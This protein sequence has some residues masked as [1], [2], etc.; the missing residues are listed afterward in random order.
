M[1]TRRVLLL[2]GCRQSGKTTLAK[3]LVS[4]DTEYRTLDDIDMLQA[5]RNDPQAFAKHNGHK[6]LIIDEVQHAP[7]LLPAIKKVVDENTRPG[8]YLLTGSANIQS[9]PGVIES[10]AGRVRK[11][12]LRPLAQGE[13]FGQSPTFLEQA[14][15]QSFAH[16]YGKY[17]KDNVLQIAFRGG[18]AEVIHL[19]DLEEGKIWY[20]DYL[21]S[22]LER[23]LKDIA[24]IRR[25]ASMRGLLKALAAWSS[26]FMDISAISSGL[27]LQR[28]TIE[29]Y[30]NALE[31]LYIIERL[32]PWTSTDYAR[33]AKQSKLFMTDCGLMSSLLGWQMDQVRLDVDRAGKMIETFVYNQLMAQIEAN[34]KAYEIYHYRDR[35]QREIDFLIENDRGALLGIEVKAGSV[36]AE[37]NFKHL[38][39]FKNNLAKKRP[40][41]GIVLYTGQVTIP[42]DQ[43]MWGIPISILWS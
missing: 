40:F 31:A 6:T 14:F 33:V 39:W 42:F 37:D 9:L 21:D 8:Q 18:Y 24:N 25:K 36:L 23:D 41:I 28:P 16:T 15:Q 2:H 38:R 17:D 22:L 4:K 35:E 32:H 26:R 34:N 10:L 3:E 27:S 7:L 19:N 5:A 20:K 12:R 13:I 30:I 29:S 1:Q 43:S 11:I